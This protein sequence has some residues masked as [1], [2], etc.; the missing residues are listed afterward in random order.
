[1][2]LYPLNTNA[3]Q[4][5]QTDA[6]TIQTSILTPVRYDAGS[7]GAIVANHYVT[8][9]AMKVGAYTLANLSP[10]GGGARN[11]TVTHTAVSTV[12][13]LGTI[14]VVGLD[15]A[16]NV[17]TD[18][19]TPLNGTIASG[20]YAFASITS[21]TGVGWVTAAGDDT[22]VVGFGD[23]VGLPDKLPENTVQYLVFNG[24]KEAS[25]ASVFSS[26]VLALNTV[27]PTSALNAST[28]K[29]VYLV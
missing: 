21:I 16:G 19:I 22:I 3:N 26:T 24:V 29:V 18:T 11:V 12:D 7:P 6:P 5:A 8:S 4:K 15:L 13:T 20:T 9:V 17:I 14:V 28:L 2:G 27:D 25:A 23:V 1:M 10:V